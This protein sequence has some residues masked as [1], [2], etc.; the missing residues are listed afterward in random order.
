[1]LNL[2][3]NNNQAQ[4]QPRHP[5]QYVQRSLDENQMLAALPINALVCD[6]ETAKIT[7][8]NEASI[9]TLKKIEDHIHVKASEIVGTPVDVLHKSFA[10]QRHWFQNPNNLPHDATIEVGPETLELHFEALKDTKGNYV[11]TILT[12]DIVTERNKMLRRNEELLE[13][14]DKMPINAMMCDPESLAITYMNHSSVQALKTLQNHLSVNIDTIIGKTID[15]FHSSLAHQRN[16]LSNPNSLPWHTQFKIGPETVDMTVSAIVSESGIYLGPLATWSVIS[17]EFTLQNTVTKTVDQVAGEVGTLEEQAASMSA[18]AEENIALA[19]AASQA[20]SEATNNVQ[21]VASASEEMAASI[22][23]ISSQVIHASSISDKASARASEANTEAQELSEASAKITEVVK[24]IN[25]IANQTNLLALNATI[26][27][28]RAG[29]AGKG[30]AVVASEVKSLANQTAQA[31]EDISVQ[32]GSIQAQT[33]SVVTA[34][35]EISTVINEV[36]EIASAIQSSTEQQGAATQEI[37]QSVG[38]AAS[39]TQEVSSQMSEVAEAASQTAEAA[40]QVQLASST[41]SSLASS[42][43]EEVKKKKKKN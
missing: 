16:I 12:W 23:E 15:V 26:E 36:S 33:K 30:F 21:A 19:Q 39:R 41:L 22:S 9:A 5:S 37:S 6:P 34:I 14:I 20:S 25:D 35:S 3:S 40:Q 42:L 13:M 28:A 2:F 38:E 4:S 24:L 17:N 8:A 29:D 27:A 32:V 7:F 18:I 11:K 1:M 10:D 31:T 43:G